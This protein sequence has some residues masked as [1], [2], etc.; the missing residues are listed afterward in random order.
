MT[1]FRRPWACGTFTPVWLP[2]SGIRRASQIQPPVPGSCA[3][4]RAR[5]R[6]ACIARRGG[7]SLEAGGEGLL[8]L[9]AACP[10]TLF[11]VSLAPLAS[12]GGWGGC[13]RHPAPAARCCNIVTCT[14][15]RGSRSVLAWRL[16]DD[17]P[18]AFRVV[19]ACRRGR[20]A[21]EPA[22]PSDL[23]RIAWAAAHPSRW[24]RHPR[25][26]RLLIRRAAAGGDAT[27]QARTAREYLP[28]GRRSGAR[29]GSRWRLF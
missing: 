15:L 1:C 28:R 17:E 23:T 6:L 19:L 5:R 9:V 8:A 12:A 3:G 24:T 10:F 16:A 14:E 20:A 21:A 26:W 7:H 11:E 29:T 2:D 4:A 25:Y 27:L 22:R 18:L 13:R